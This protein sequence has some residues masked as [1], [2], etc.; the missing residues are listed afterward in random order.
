MAKDN[1]HKNSRSSIN[2]ASPIRERSDKKKSPSGQKGKEALTNSLRPD[3]LKPSNRQTL[4]N[5]VKEEAKRIPDVRRDRIKQIRA[6]IQSREYHISSNL[7]AD[8]IIQDILWDEYPIQ[9]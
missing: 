9:E 1:L 7:L 4:S 5:F 2:G 3:P 6:A 8:R